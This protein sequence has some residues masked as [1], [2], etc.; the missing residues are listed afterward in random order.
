MTSHTVKYND[1]IIITWHHR[2]PHVERRLARVVRDIPIPKIM[3]FIT[4]CNPGQ[5]LEV[6]IG[7]IKH[8]RFRRRVFRGAG[9]WHRI[10]VGRFSRRILI[11][12]WCR[13]SWGLA[14][15][16]RPVKRE[17]LDCLLRLIPDFEETEIMCS[18]KIKNYTHSGGVVEFLSEFLLESFE[19][20]GDLWWGIDISGH[21]ALLCSSGNGQQSVDNVHLTL[22]KALLYPNIYIYTY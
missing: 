8:G 22:R 14:S 18:K 19:G 11:W 12:A 3:Y 21:T 4:R 17:M 10:S 7:K 5:G 6:I 1:V 2:T 13:Q 15:L 16:R 9:G 20:I